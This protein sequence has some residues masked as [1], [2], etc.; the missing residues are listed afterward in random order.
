METI[1]SNTGCDHYARNLKQEHFYHVSDKEPKPCDYCGGDTRFVEFSAFNVV[2]TGTIT[3]RYNDRSIENWHVEGHWAYR[4]KS[5]PDGKPKGEYITTFQQQKE[6]CRAEGLAL[7]QELP[8]NF[9]VAEDGKTVLNTCGMPG[10]E[11]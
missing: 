1:C 2:F 4:T 8:R 10:T 11:I 6:F 3:A 7:P 5:T 9:H